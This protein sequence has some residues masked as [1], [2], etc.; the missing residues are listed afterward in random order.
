MRSRIA[1]LRALVSL[2]V[3]VVFVIAVTPGSMAM[4]APQQTMQMD[5]AA[6]PCDQS[7]KDRGK[8]CKSMVVCFG[9]LSCF[10]M[11]AIATEHFTFSKSAIAERALA[12]HQIVS[13]LTI[14][15]DDR[16]PIA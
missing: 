15:P 9:M 1:S 6:M 14:P 5:C 10:G 3:A 8:P 2:F 13:G 11:A 7:H 4:P 12:L 16:P